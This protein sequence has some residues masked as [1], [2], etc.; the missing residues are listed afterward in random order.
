M[1]LH[2][3]KLATLPIKSDAT[4]ENPESE[5]GKAW[6]SIIQTILA[7][8]GAQRMHWG[9]QVEHPNLVQTIVGMSPRH[10]AHQPRSPSSPLRN[11]PHPIP[12]S[13]DAYLP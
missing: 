9:R 8:E 2:I 4:I 7:Q 11:P 10:G 3:T 13:F 12:P 5:A 6:Q 1:P